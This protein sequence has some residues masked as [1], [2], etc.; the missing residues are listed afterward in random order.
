MSE[1]IR[2]PNCGKI[3]GE[4]EGDHINIKKIDLLVYGA[5]AM[6]RKCPRCGTLLDMVK[7]LTK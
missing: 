1:E 6:P 3:L 4:R 2:C 5:D 7:I